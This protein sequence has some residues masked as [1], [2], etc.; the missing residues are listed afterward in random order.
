[1]KVRSK[2]FYFLLALLLTNSPASGQPLRQFLE[3]L[4]SE[5]E[6]IKFAAIGYAYGLRDGVGEMQ[7]YYGGL[8]LAA[9]QFYAH[10]RLRV[11]ATSKLST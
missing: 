3:D 7:N 11:L 6:A 5:D 4:Q 10:L 2:F 9:P 1:M 8:N